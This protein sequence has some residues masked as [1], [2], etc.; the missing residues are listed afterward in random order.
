MSVLS[1]C[2]LLQTAAAT[3]LAVAGANLFLVRILGW[4]ESLRQ[5]PLLVR[6]VFHVHLWF[7]S[8]TLAMFAILTWRFAEEMASGADPALRWLAGAMAGFWALRTL[9][10]VVYYSPSHWWGQTARTLIHVACLVIYGGLASLYLAVCWT[11]A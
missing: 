9:L 8:F 3:Q 2:W 1:L 7:I 6:E 4:R 10:Q 5:L 11:G